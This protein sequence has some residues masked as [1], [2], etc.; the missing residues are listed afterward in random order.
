MTN[1][2]ALTGH[3]VDC[4]LDRDNNTESCFSS[5]GENKFLLSMVPRLITLM[6]HPFTTNQLIK[7]KALRALFLHDSKIY[8][9]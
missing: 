3:E 4:W 5:W 9:G 8:N 2:I 1:P 7:I 6:D